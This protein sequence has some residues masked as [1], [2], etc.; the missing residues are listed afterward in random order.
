MIHQQ[1]HRWREIPGFAAHPIWV[2]AFSWLEQ[3]SP[4]EED[5]I[6]PLGEPRFFARVMGYPLKQ[7]E[8]GRYES[9]R[10]TIDIQLS[11]KGAEGIEVAPLDC[12]QPLDDYSIEKDVEHYLTPTRSSASVSNC[13][14]WFSIF[15]TQEAHMPQLAIPGVADVRK[16]VVKIPTYL[17]ETGT[18]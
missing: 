12:L 5:G 17:V 7:R 1:L 4:E 6:H 18:P 8:N 9:H 11:L 13:P 15:F 14:G 10:Q 3:V 16:V 2:K